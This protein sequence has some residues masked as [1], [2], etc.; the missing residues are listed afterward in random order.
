MHSDPNTDW[1]AVIKPHAR[2]FDLRLA[3]LWRY[4]DLVSLFVHRDFVARY[5]QTILGPL[6]YLIQPLLTTAVFTIVF[7]NIAG[8][9]TDGLPKFLF[10]MAGNVTWTYFSECL[11]QTHN[12][13]IANASVFGK[14][15]FPRLT[16]PVSILISNLVTFL[17]QM[18]FFLAF[19]VYF[20]WQGAD[21]RPNWYLL[22]I[23]A[24]VLF[25]AGLG[26][27]LGLVISAATTRYRDLTHLVSFGVSLFMYATPV[28]YPLSAVPETYKWLIMANPMTPLVETVRYAFLGRGGVEVI[29]LVYSGVVTLVVL[30]AGI[31]VFHRVERTFMDSI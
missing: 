6:W 31:L 30:V 4:R 11:T 17:V 23:P 1:T 3:E 16:V 19:L 29:H 22:W 24:L 25:M 10:Y 9:S 15:Y 13:F 21:I 8:I 5:K 28:V 14:V 26:L 18:L 27:G 7:G 20:S 2:W 12:V